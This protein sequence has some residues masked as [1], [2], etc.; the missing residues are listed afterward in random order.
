MSR[1]GLAAAFAIAVGGILSAAQH[2]AIMPT[3]RREFEPGFDLNEILD[4]A[5][6]RA[7]RKIRKA[8]RRGR[9]QAAQR[10]ALTG[11]PA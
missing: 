8:D 6:R 2:V 1:F 7:E 5:G 10:S 9:L 3:R 11:E 4:D